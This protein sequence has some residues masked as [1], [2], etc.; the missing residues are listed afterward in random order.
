MSLSPDDIER[1]VFA[2]EFRG[3]DREDVDTFLDRVADTLEE[4]R[5]EREGL[6]ARLN[7]AERHAADARAQADERVAAAADR[8]QQAASAANAR[9]A[10]V[11]SAASD[12]LEAEKMLKRTLITAQRTADATL[13]ELL[14]LV[15]VPVDQLPYQL[16]CLGEDLLLLRPYHLSHDRLLI[17]GVG[18]DLLQQTDI[19]SHRLHIVL[20]CL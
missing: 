5:R 8:V 18:A 2:T 19:L 6:L 13:S 14:F 15:L 1:Q 4:L 3:Y 20:Q 10:Q 9:V 16:D 17:C 12:A 7:D 11:E